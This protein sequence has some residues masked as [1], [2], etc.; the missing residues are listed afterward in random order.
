MYSTPGSDIHSVLID[1]TLKPTYF[2]GND[3]VQDLSMDSEMDYKVG[4]TTGDDY[5]SAPPVIQLP[6]QFRPS[7]PVGKRRP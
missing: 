5:T 4:S 6:S 7:A 3:A 2:I 1:A